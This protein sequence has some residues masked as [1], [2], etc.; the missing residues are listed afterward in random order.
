VTYLKAIARDSSQ[1]KSLMMARSVLFV[2]NIVGRAIHSVRA[3]DVLIGLVEN[4]PAGSLIYDKQLTR[5]EGG[6]LSFA[7]NTRPQSSIGASAVVVDKNNIY[8]PKTNWLF[9]SILF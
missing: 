9:V 2:F 6:R 5:T 3:L 1:K 4:E 8:W 7:Q